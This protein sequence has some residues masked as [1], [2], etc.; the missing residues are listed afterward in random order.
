VFDFNFLRYIFKRSKRKNVIKNLR[1]AYT[2]FHAN[3]GE[4]TRQTGNPLDTNI[5]ESKRNTNVAGVTMIKTAE[6]SW[7]EDHR[8]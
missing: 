3:M 8:T 5:S 1:T 2:A 4:D 6:H 7:D